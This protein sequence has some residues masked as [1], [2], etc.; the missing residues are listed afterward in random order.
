MGGVAHLNFALKI[1]SAQQSI[2]WPKKVVLSFFPK[3]LQMAARY[4][5]DVMF[6]NYWFYIFKWNLLL[7]FFPYYNEYCLI[8]RWSTYFFTETAV[9]NYSG[10]TEL[11]LDTYSEP[12][13]NV[14]VAWGW[15]QAS[16]QDA[17]KD[18]EEENK[19]HQPVEDWVRGRAPDSHARGREFESLRWLHPFSGTCEL[20]LLQYLETNG[21]TGGV[22]SYCK[23]RCKRAV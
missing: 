20:C 22:A 18:I 1:M 13:R 23:P 9:S 19:Q 15:I 7:S 6:V 3:I 12:K 16:W 10:T 17:L 8:Y 2:F 11:Y 21:E 5:A 14:S 4:V